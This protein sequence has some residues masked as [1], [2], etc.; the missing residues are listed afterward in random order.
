MVFYWRIKTDQGLNK[1]RGCFLF[2]SY[3]FVPLNVNP[4]LLKET[5][6]PVFLLLV[7]LGISF[8][9]APEYTIRAV[10][11]F[12]ENLRRYS[13]LEVSLT[14]VAIAKNLQS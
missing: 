8:P 14:P 12:F 6:S 1:V 4:G 2:Y 5:V 7:L 3:I 10:W 11:N 13:Q 9:Q